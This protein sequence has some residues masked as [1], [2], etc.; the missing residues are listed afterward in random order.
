MLSSARGI[1]GRT[2]NDGNPLRKPRIRPTTVPGEPAA[3]RATDASVRAPGGEASVLLV[4]HGSR[5]ARANEQFDELVAAYA[6]V[7]PELEVGC[8]CVELA[9][10]SL[11]E[12]LDRLARR[13]R[14]VVVLPAFLFAARHVK[15]DLPLALQDARA[16]HPGVGFEC[17]RVLGIDTEL[18]C[19]A[20][21]L[22]D[23]ALAGADRARTAL[24]IVGR[25]SSDPD[26]NGDFAKQARLIEEGRGWA[27]VA[28][29][30]L[31]IT[32]PDVP[33]VLEQMA[34]ARPLRLVVLPYLLFPG[35]LIERLEDQVRRFAQTH[36][37]I[38]VRTAE[39]LGAG[40]ALVHAL[41]RRL[42]GVLEGDRPLACDACVYRVELPGR[43][44][45]LGGLRALL[46]SLRHTE[47]HAQSGPHR[48]AH[49]PVERHVFVCTNADCAAR[50]SPALVAEL[51]RELERAGLARSVRVT[52]SACLGR[53]GEGPAVAVY[54][55]GIWY[56]GVGTNDAR[57]LVSEHL[58]ADRLVG[59]LIDTILT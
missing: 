54:P 11:R 17:A 40:P 39:P 56:R 22:G 4:G 41:D 46:W 29:A 35:R 59:R 3:T 2:T 42:A 30:F 21:R 51:R 44:R 43:A 5:D 32:T 26:A 1:Q 58:Q 20:A 16:R 12:G 24:L 25:G 19:E 36:P 34:A 38:G 28:T 6:R 9:G 27:R 37:W 49:R 15:N 50:G 8:A 18:A 33:T 13:S 7:H 57:E 55:D 48:H 31:G 52:R 47:T 10:P 23:A 14:R 45:E 53:C